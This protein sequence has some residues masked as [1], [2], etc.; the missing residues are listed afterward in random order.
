MEGMRRISGVSGTLV[1]NI[2]T[3][4]FIAA[5]FAN[6]TGDLIPIIWCP[7]GIRINYREIAYV[8]PAVGWA[9]GSGMTITHDKPCGPS[10]S[11]DLSTRVIASPGLAL[12]PLAPGTVIC[13]MIGTT[14]KAEKAYFLKGADRT[15]RDPGMLRMV[16]RHW[17]FTPAMV[18]GRPVASWQRIMIQSGPIIGEVVPTDHRPAE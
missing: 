12:M 15:S 16:R 10:A 8:D 9:S 13:A 2:A 4:S 6:P 1:A 14:G 3:L 7:M 17:S 18:G 11:A 5:A